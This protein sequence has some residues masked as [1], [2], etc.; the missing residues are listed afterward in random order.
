[1]ECFLELRSYFVAGGA[2]AFMD[3]VGHGDGSARFMG[4]D[5][6]GKEADGSLLP[7]VALIL[8]AGGAAVLM[9]MVNHGDSMARFMRVRSGW[10]TT[11]R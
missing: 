11:T 10:T 9:V 7:R 8:A 2:A 3:I 5:Q 4:S 1:M 6:H